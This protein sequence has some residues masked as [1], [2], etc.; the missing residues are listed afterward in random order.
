[1]EMHLLV[2]GEKKK[3]HRIEVAKCIKC[4]ICSETCR[5]QAIAAA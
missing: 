5:Q 4:G 1:M 2:A 3:P